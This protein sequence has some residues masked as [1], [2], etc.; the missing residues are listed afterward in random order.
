MK[1]G[2][3][4]NIPLPSHFQFYFTNS[5]QTSLIPISQVQPTIAKLPTAISNTPKKRAPKAQKLGEDGQ[6]LPKTPAKKAAKAPVLDKDGNPV[7]KAPAPRKPAAPKVDAE[8]NPIPK[9]PRKKQEPKLGG[10]GHPIPKGLRKNA[11]KKSKAELKADGQVDD[12]MGVVGD[13]VGADLLGDESFID[14]ANTNGTTIPFARPAHFGGGANIDEDIMS[15]QDIADGNNLPATPAGKG[16]KAPAKARVNSTP[17]DAKGIAG[18]VLAA[19]KKK[20]NVED[21]ADEDGDEGESPT[22]KKKANAL[23]TTWAELS[24]ADALL[25]ALKKEGR[26]MA[27]II[28][29]WAKLSGVEPKKST[30]SVRYSRI[31]AN[32]TEWKNGDV[33]ISYFPCSSI[34]VFCFSC[35][36]KFA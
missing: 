17:G 12:E 21:V 13:M 25:I 3:L 32:L 36:C 4:P 5:L 14:G 18:G 28:P 10:D 20:R 1:L 30:L 27:E 16:K 8:G 15:F 22:K 23:P 34:S 9:A 29:Q 26:P 2:I 6:P 11:P 24:D 31:M 7:K 33:S 35:L 19:N